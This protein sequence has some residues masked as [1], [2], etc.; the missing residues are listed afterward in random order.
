MC[1][2][3]DTF[4]I[5]LTIQQNTA[6]LQSSIHLESTTLRG[7]AHRHNHYCPFSALKRIASREGIGASDQTVFFLMFA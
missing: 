2:I 6:N 3:Y 5:L 1:N 7:I 4:N